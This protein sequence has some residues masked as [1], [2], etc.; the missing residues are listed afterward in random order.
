MDTTEMEVDTDR[1]DVEPEI[2]VVE[3]ENRREVLYVD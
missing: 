1:M 3:R 2:L